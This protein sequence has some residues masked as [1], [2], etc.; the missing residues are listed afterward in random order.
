VNSES[1]GVPALAAQKTISDAYEF[2]LQHIGL[3]VEASSVWMEYLAFI[4]SWAAP[5]PL[6]ES[7]RTD[8]LRK[9]YQ[10]AIVLPQH[11]VEAIWRDYD[12][13]ENSLNKFSVCHI[14]IIIFV[15]L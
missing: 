10:R 15:A 14:F 2:A 9:V 8:T 7:R 11:S 6:D 12:A 5:T 3:D 1:A 13:F 4:K